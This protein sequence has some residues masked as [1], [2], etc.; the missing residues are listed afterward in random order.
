MCLREYS[1]RRGIIAFAAAAVALSVS[2]CATFT[3]DM[4]LIR[5][6]SPEEKSGLLVQKGIAL[7][8]EKL[9]EENDLQ[10]V[11]SIRA[12]FVNALGA[13]PLNKTAESYIA[14]IDSFK[15]ERLKT[16]LAKAQKLKDKKNR[17]DRENYELCLTVQRAAAL[18]SMNRDAVILKLETNDIRKQV[19]QK[20]VAALA[21]MEKKLLAEKN[22]SNVEKIIPQAAKTIS[23]VFVIDPINKDA[24]RTRKTVEEYVT[25]RARA[26]ITLS[27]KLLA[28]KD[29]PGAKA[30]IE[31]AERTLKGFEAVPGPEV[32]ALKYKISY[33]WA[34]ELY[35]QKKYE[36]ADMRVSEAIKI[37]R[38]PEAADLKS[39][40][41][42]SRT[43]KDYDSDADDIIADI[44]ARLA[45]RDLEGAWGIVENAESKM[46]QQANKD[47]IS[48]KKA[49]II[50][51]IKGIYDDAVAAYNEENYEDARDGLRVVVRINPG[52]QQAQAYLDKSNGKLRA[53]EGSD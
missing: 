21:E 10:A 48:A 36:S 34:L 50:E 33:R 2:A 25:S 5:E 12:I 43:T 37:N 46:A 1:M 27:E 11:P 22:Q 53:L 42:K 28:K 29:F 47:R 7:Y 40:I 4:F 44:D 49:A 23:E 9:M 8:N 26:D 35:S 3:A 15:T 19:I 38:T 13:D 20:R 6:C 17:T 14:K 24:E 45:A 39:R 18:D 32:K 31:R 51:R 16:Y 30:A 41:A 52:Y